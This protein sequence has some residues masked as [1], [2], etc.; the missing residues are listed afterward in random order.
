MRREDPACWLHHAQQPSIYT[1]I[2][3]QHHP[4]TKQTD[5]HTHTHSLLASPLGSAGG[6]TP[7]GQWWGSGGVACCWSLARRRA[8]DVGE[9]AECLDSAQM[10]YK[11]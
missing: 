3:Q 2:H 4:P 6:G 9:A 7:G 8:W 11:Q 10:V 5:T 1:D